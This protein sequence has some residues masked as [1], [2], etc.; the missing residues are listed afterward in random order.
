MTALIKL[1]PQEPTAS[2]GVRLVPGSH[3]WGVD[4]LNGGGAWLDEQS[5]A[6]AIDQQVVI[7]WAAGTAVLMDPSLFHA[8]G[9][10]SQGRERAV[11]SLAVRA[12]DELL[13]GPLENEIRV[14]GLHEYHGQ[15]WWS[16]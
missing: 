12:S 7:S 2:D 15:Q 9:S 8:A 11:L 13:E 14:S 16:A 1:S 10:G 5:Y 4:N 6:E 3:W